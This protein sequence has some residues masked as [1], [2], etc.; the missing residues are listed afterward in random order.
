LNETFCGSSEYISPEMLQQRPYSYPLDFY[1]LGA[2]LYEMV[3]G[4][5]P[6]F[7]PDSKKMFENVATKKL[8]FPAW[9][10]AELK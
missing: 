6:F 9:F 4:L 1:S 10:S 5:P 3:A 8:G 7:D 2:V